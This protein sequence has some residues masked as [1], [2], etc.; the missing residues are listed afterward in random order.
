MILSKTA[1]GVL[2]RRMAIGFLS[3]V[4]SLSSQYLTFSALCLGIILPRL[5]TINFDVFNVDEAVYLL[6][7]RAWRFGALPYVDIVDRKPLGLYFIS[8]FAD[9]IASNAIIGARALGIVSTLATAWL[10]LS[11][12]VRYL[13]LTKSA[14]HV[15]ALLYASF[16]LLFGGD[17]I[18]APVY[19]AP[20]LVGAA[21]LIMVE[22][23][24]IKN[25]YSPSVWRAAFVGL[26]LGITFQIKY[27]TG[28]EATA[29]AIAYLIAGWSTRNT[30]GLKLQSFVAAAVMTVVSIM[31][32]VAS[33]CVYALKG[34]GEEFIFYVFTS[35]F[36]REVNDAHPSTLMRRIGMLT[37]FML[38]LLLMAGD[39]VR[40]ARRQEGKEDPEKWVVIF[41]VSWA[42]AALA[43]AI[44][45]MQ[46]YDNNFYPML[47]PLALLAGAELAKLFSRN[48]WRYCLAACA[49]ISLALAGYA[50]IRIKDVLHN[51][52]P[53]LLSR[54]AAGLVEGG[55]SSLY[56]F[57]YHTLL[58]AKARLPLLTKFPLASHLTRDL[59]AR[60]FRI[61]GA[62][63]ISRIV[64]TN[65][66]AVVVV[67]PWVD[68][69]IDRQMIVQK[70]LESDYCLW[71]TYDA[72]RGD[73]E[74]FISRAANITAASEACENPLVPHSRFEG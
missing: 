74:I 60:S 49:A 56:V 13:R 19:Y 33:Y 59:E 62:A 12:G 70:K 38:P 14:A 10:L 17:T 5:V 1:G 73:V 42:I 18:E 29:F 11:I 2:P 15:A 34:Y 65:P 27:V 54:I 45:Q 22:I 47:M 7:G 25:S 61:D 53:H 8:G 40:R 68:I 69:P 41:L 20:F 30:P 28:A 4:Q 72:G 51:G 21:Y 43:S 39:Y 6:I 31:P 50:Y 24:R 66:Q 37:I 63:E 55:V 26:L 36:S 35:N 57:N 71:R 23:E 46:F 67:K 44:A 3:N 48:T 58:H 64:D 16:A 32:L 9:A 52:S